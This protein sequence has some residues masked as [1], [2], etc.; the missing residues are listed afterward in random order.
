MLN[1]W[2]VTYNEQNNNVKS[3]VNEKFNSVLFILNRSYYINNIEV[4]L[5]I[6]LK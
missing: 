3:V 5:I 1:I 6:K 2:N 4:N